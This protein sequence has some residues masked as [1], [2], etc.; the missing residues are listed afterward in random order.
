MRCAM[1]VVAAT[2]C[3]SSN[4]GVVCHV[5]YVAR[6]VYPELALSTY[7]DWLEMV[8]TAQNSVRIDCFSCLVMY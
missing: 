4:Q 3:C 8:R 1:L 5:C 7:L 6:T 2:H